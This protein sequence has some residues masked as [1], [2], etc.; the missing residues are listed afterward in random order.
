[1][2]PKSENNCLVDDN[3]VVFHS[4][5]LRHKKVVRS[6]F[7]FISV[8]LNPELVAIFLYFFFL[9]NK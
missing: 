3:R 5:L 9:L 4:S 8:Y 6:F 1:M 7:L 2:H